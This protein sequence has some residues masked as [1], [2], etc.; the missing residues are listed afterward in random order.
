[1]D[2]SRFLHSVLFSRPP[3]RHREYSGRNIPSG[4]QQISDAFLRLNVAMAQRCVITHAAR[5]GGLIHRAQYACA[6]IF[7]CRFFCSAGGDAFRVDE[8]DY[9]RRVLLRKILLPRSLTTFYKSSSGNLLSTIFYNHEMCRLPAAATKRRKITGFKNR[10]EI[11]VG[12]SHFSGPSGRTG[13]G[14]HF[15]SPIMM[16]VSLL[17]RV[18]L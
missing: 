11:V 8:D 5:A 2:S 18:N 3:P 7:Y 16:R 9:K 10:S 6:M 13:K 14:A 12:N 1:M 17:P 4:D 15:P